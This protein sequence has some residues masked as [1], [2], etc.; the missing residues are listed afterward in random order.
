MLLEAVT[1]V[2]SRSCTTTIEI[3][4]FLFVSRGRS[5]KRGRMNAIVK[6]VEGTSL[7][8]NAWRTFYST[9]ETRFPTSTYLLDSRRDRLAC[10]CEFL[11]RSLLLLLLLTFAGVDP[12]VLPS[13]SSSSR[14]PPRILFVSALFSPSSRSRSRQSK[15]H[16][17]AEV[18]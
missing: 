9:G 3:F 11:A 1:R 12:H 4:L 18:P 6:R 7:V 17:A 15:F 5:R 13:L 10:L 16:V 8:Q 2:P 14:T